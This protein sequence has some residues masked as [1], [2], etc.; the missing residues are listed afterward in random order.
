MSALASELVPRKLHSQ[1]KSTKANGCRKMIEIPSPLSQFCNILLLSILDKCL[2]KRDNARSSLLSA[3]IDRFKRSDHCR[4]P[5]CRIRTTPEQPQ[6]RT[7]VLYCETERRRCLKM[8]NK[9]RPLISV[10]RIL[11]FTGHGSSYDAV[12]YEECQPWQSRDWWNS[13][14]Q[15][16]SVLIGL[17][18]RAA[19]ELVSMSDFPLYGRLDFSGWFVVAS[20]YAPFL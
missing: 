9:F 3:W 1:R 10:F 7:S 5:R 13:F 12:S 4:Y 16:P 17:V 2:T 18:L 8:I 20:R 15:V 19:V 6:T 11:L 14:Q